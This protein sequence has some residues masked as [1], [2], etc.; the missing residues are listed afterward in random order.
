MAA[1]FV[2]VRHE[3]CPETGGFIHVSAP[4]HARTGGHGLPGV[5]D[6][7]EEDSHPDHCAVASVRREVALPH[8]P[9]AFLPSDSGLTSTVANAP[10]ALP[11]SLRFFIAPKQ[12]PPV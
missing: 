6:A 2:L 7:G 1:H 9:D 12:S 10:W 3:Y 4:G 5:Y 11:S 8:Q